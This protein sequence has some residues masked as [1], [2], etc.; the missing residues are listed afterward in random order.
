MAL[1]FGGYTLSNTPFDFYR[2][3]TERV[4]I[5]ALTVANVTGNMAG[6][7]FCLGEPRR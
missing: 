7:C 4:N 3:T 6:C 2:R 1:I 5:A